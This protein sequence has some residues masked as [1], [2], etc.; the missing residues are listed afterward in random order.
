MF[1]L[2]L[3]YI[4]LI[5][6]AGPTTKVLDL[7][8]ALSIIKSGGHCCL[9]E[10]MQGVH[11]WFL[12]NC[13]FCRAPLRSDVCRGNRVGSSLEHKHWLPPA[14]SGGR[15]Y[16][17]PEGPDETQFGLIRFVYCNLAGLVVALHVLGGLYLDHD[18][19]LTN[20]NVSPGQMSLWIVCCPSRRDNLGLPQ[21]GIKHHQDGGLH[22][23]RVRRHPERDDSLGD[24]RGGDRR[25]V[26]FRVVLPPEDGLNGPHYSGMVCSRGH[27]RQPE[28]RADVTQVVLDSSRH[29]L[30]IVEALQVHADLVRQRSQGVHPCVIAEPD[31]GLYS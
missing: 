3:L 11:F 1:V 5:R 25:P 24:G 20:Y 6:I 22:G 21:C 27:P 18:C 9:A 30:P 8:V 31:P 7:A 16:H 10:A 13:H 28:V 29:Q 17:L 14:D 2:L 12:S 15:R 4:D 23:H 26:D 19:F